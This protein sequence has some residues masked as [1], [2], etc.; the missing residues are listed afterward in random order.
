MDENGWPGRMFCCWFV[1]VLVLVCK[2]A[3]HTH[4]NGQ[5]CANGHRGNWGRGELGVKGK[6]GQFDNILTTT[7]SLPF[8]LDFQWPSFRPSS[9]LQTR[10]RTLKSTTSAYI[11]NMPRT[12]D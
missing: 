8:Q 11:I 7:I 4:T 1:C 6:S 12:N 10:P 9:S 2:D 3:T 5:M